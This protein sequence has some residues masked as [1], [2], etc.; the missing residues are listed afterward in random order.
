MEK[1]LNIIS[2]ISFIITFII[3]THARWNTHQHQKKLSE[4]KKHPDKKV[5]INASI[6]YDEKLSNDFTILPLFICIGSLIV[7]GLLDSD[8]TKFLIYIIMVIAIIVLITTAVPILFNGIKKI[9]IILTGNYEVT[10]VK[11]TKKEIIEISGKKELCLEFDNDEFSYVDYET[12]QVV[13]E[14]DEFYFLKIGLIAKA[15]DKRFYKI[16]GS[17]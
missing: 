5:E 4:A 16:K 11:I 13:N 2:I 9:N 6:L 15:F 3:Y 17:E 8:L 1:V 10:T 14:G 12:H 7:N